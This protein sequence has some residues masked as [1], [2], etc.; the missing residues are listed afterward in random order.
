MSDSEFQVPSGVSQV[1]VLLVGGGGGGRWGQG[2]GAYSGARN[3]LNLTVV[4]GTKYKIVVGKG[5]QSGSN[6]GWSEFDQSSAKGG[7]SDTGHECAGSRYEGKDADWPQRLS[8][9]KQQ[10]IREGADGPSRGIANAGGRGG[11]GIV[12]AWEEKV[13]FAGYSRKTA[14]QFRGRGGEGY[15]AGGGAGGS[16]DEMR[17]EGGD[18]FHGLVYIEWD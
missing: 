7:R 5:G 16:V 15:G 13:F 4:T 1:R 8:V 11:G 9:L 6:G 12:M 3:L 17:R 2:C 14:T 18:G 10:K